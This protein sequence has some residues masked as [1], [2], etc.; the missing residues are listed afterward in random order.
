MLRDG[1]VAWILL[2]VSAFQIPSRGDLWLEDGEERYVG[3]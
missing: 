2:V 1:A 3:K